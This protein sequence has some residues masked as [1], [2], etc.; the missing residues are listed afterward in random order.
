MKIDQNSIHQANCVDFMNEMDEE[1][2]DLVVTSP[3]YDDLRDYKGYS[4]PFEKIA[5]WLFRVVKKWWVVVW[6]VW[7]KI[8]KWNKSLTWFKQALYFQEIWFNVHDIMIYKKKN[9]PF[10]RSNGYTNCFEFMYIF[11]K[12]SPKTFNPIKEWTVRQWFETMPVNK[13]PD[14]KNNKVLRELKAEKTLNNIWEYAVWLHWTTSD[15]F[16]FEHPA[17]FPEKLAED[18]IIS[19]TNENDIVFDPMCWSWTT[20]KMALK[21]NRKY[22]WCDISIE[23][24]NISQKRI[25]TITNCSQG[26][27]SLFW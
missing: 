5:Q 16:A 15:K 6:V 10:M 12:W 13:W 8:K 2:I 19:W 20:C 14:G 1:S 23:Y 7:D 24:V 11:S 9:T 26:N 25:E 18:H 27:Q 17:V 4:F 3:P 22:I 21:N